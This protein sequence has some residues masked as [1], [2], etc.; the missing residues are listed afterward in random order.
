M[1]NTK[2]K[3]TKQ[4]Q[5]NQTQKTRQGH[6]TKKRSQNGNMLHGQIKYH[7]Q[8]RIETRMFD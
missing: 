8:E 2:L 5:K 3:T 6:A 4:L 1:N 7:D